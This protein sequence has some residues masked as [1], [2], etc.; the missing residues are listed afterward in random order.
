MAARAQA[1]ALGRP[2][3]DAVYVVHPIQDQT[4]AEI[5]A[6]VDAVLNEIV[7]RLTAQISGSA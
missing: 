1:A 3:F 7:V 5:E 2:D 4:K 6:K